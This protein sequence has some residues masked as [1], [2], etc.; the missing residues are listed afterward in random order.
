MK[1]SVIIIIETQQATTKDVGQ[2]L[3]S[4]LQHTGSF[5]VHLKNGAKKV[6]QQAG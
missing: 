1:H 5:F 3:C 4:C 2:T 6:I